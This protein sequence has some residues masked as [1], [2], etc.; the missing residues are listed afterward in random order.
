[1]I[2]RLDE[3]LLYSILDE[4]EEETLFGPPAPVKVVKIKTP[5]KLEV[6]QPYSRP[7][8]RRES[9]QVTPLY[10]SHQL[11]QQE[12]KKCLQEEDFVVPK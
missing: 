9:L 3:P 1:M 7:D 2:Q 8:K 4:E 10:Q 5:V 12:V 11:L 6:K